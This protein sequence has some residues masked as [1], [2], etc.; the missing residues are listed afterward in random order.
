LSESQR[1][2]GDEESGR[3]KHGDGV[4]VLLYWRRLK[5][6]SWFE[7]LEWNKGERRLG[8][9]PPARPLYIFDVSSLPPPFPERPVLNPTFPTFKAGP[10]SR[11]RWR[12]RLKPSGTRTC[13][14]ASADMEIEFFLGP[15]SIDTAIPGIRIETGPPSAFREKSH[16]AVPRVDVHFGLSD[17][18]RFGAMRAMSRRVLGCFVF[19]TVSS[20]SS[21][22]RRKGFG[23]NRRDFC[24]R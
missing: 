1:Q 20:E 15:Y 2:G 24:L 22:M 10:C 3:D 6:E 17:K 13:S 7:F 18:I 5:I 12:F 11:I 19:G 8:M 16:E 9:H 21:H 23:R 14:L 4:E